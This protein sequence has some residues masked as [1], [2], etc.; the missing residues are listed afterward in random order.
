VPAA[1]ACIDTSLESVIDRIRAQLGADA[2]L[3]APDAIEPYLGDFRGLF[4][5]ATR[6]VVL[7]RSTT[8]VA[9]VLSICNESTVGIVPQGGNT[10]Y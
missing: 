9:A 7:P 5:G 3:E 4:R 2:C 1:G 10:S 8:E 6:L